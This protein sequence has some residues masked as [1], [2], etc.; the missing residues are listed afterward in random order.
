MCV[1]L[2]VLEA[3]VRVAGLQGERVIA[4]SDFHRLPGNA[5]ERDTNL[6]A[7][8]I[9]TAVELPANGF[10]KNHTY[11]KIRDRLSYA[12]ALVSVAAALELDGNTIKEAR[13]ALG[14]VAHK[15]W[16]DPSVEAAMRGQP[17][18]RET[19][20]QAADG[21]L[22]DAKGHAH[23]AFKIELARRA[24]D[25]GADASRAGH[26]AIASL[27]KDPVS[28]MTYIGTPTSRID[29]HAKVTGAARYAAEHRVDGLVHAAVVTS[30]IAKGRIAR[31]E[32]SEALRVEGVL[33]ILT[34]EN[35]PP[36]ARAT[37]VWK[38]DVAPEQ[39]APFRP[40]YDDKILFNRQPIALVLAE[41]WEI[42]RLAATLVRVEYKPERFATDIFAERDKAVVIEKPELTTRQ[43]RRGLRGGSRTPRGGIFH[44][45]RASQSD[46]IV[47]FDRGLGGWRRAHSLRQDTGCSERA[48][49][50]CAASST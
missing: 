43:S 35:R 11:L 49:V 7:D 45:D 46:G 17:A 40:L 15:P 38:D 5:P 14:G 42:A 13:L 23:N 9:I 34:H 12:F 30:T 37:N 4:F 41:E 32:T 33:D 1:A 10:A 47:R 31:I 39:G 36:M 22:R 27:Q 50:I 24:S 26:A 8:E 28:A 20:M 44:P 6:A 25:A 19:F 18:K 21:L 29:G 3:K 48:A 16:R 2:A